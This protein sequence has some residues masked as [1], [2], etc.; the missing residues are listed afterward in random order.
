MHTG[1]RPLEDDP[2][3]AGQQEVNRLVNELPRYWP[4]NVFDI[5]T[6]RAAR[7]HLLKHRPRVLYIGLGETD[8]WAH[9]RRYDLYLDAAHRSDQYL[10]ELWETLQ[11]LPE[12]KDRT[13]LVVTTDHGRGSTPRDWTNH[14][15]DTPEAE[16]IWIGVLGPDVP[17][18]GI[19]QDATTTQAQVA[20]TLAQLVGEDFVAASSS[21]APPLPLRP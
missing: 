15:A 11:S 7:E 14:S 20:A 19:R 18:L 2:L 21:A 6:H 10:R 9:A 8:E 5:V 17:G 12:Y 3:T 13:A 4:G 16:F 1:W